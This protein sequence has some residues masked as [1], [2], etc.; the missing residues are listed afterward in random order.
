MIEKLKKRFPVFIKNPNLVFFD[1]AASALKVDSMI[2]TTNDVYSFEYSNIHRGLYDLS[3]KLTKRYEESR[4][5]VSKFINSPSE[6]NIIFT[7]S[8]TEG[9]N[10]V[11]SCLSKNYFDDG[12]EVIVTQLEHHSNLVPWHLV[13]KKIKIISVGLNNNFEIDYNDLINK[14]NS[15]TKLVAI[16]HMSNITGA[17][18]ELE[19]FNFILKKN[20]IPLLVDG[21]Q[22]VPHNKLDLSIL[23]PDF[24]VF[25][26]HKLYGP[27]G[28]GILYMNNKWLDRL[29]PY[30]GG[31][32]MIKNVEINKSSYSEGFEKFEAGTPPINQVISLASSIKFIEQIGITKINEQEK[33]LTN[34]FVEKLKSIN[35][36]IFYFDEYKVNSILSFNAKLIHFNDLGIFLDKK[37]IAI[38]TGHHCAQP[39]MR[40]NNIK[41]NAR[42]SIGIYND[43]HDIDYFIESLKDVLSFLK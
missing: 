43:F 4:K 9:I 13:E 41:G 39:F 21:C 42:A 12:D 33:K 8:A 14:I 18:T 2:K 15:K 27:S 19:K 16:T 24:Y 3:S 37:N 25:S 30:Q 34:Y 40:Y 22:Y 20:N 23:D 17:V 36:L 35:D 10:L 28:L 11:S 7:K 29:G 31:G 1:T 6:K 5:S 32:S 38:R 26:A